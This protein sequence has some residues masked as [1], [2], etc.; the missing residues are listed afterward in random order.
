MSDRRY[1]SADVVVVGGGMSG[2]C[3]SIAAA[4]NGSS[5]VLIQDRPVLGGNAS[6]E[7]RMHIVG[8]DASGHRRGLDS[9][10]SG[11]IE[12]IRLEEAV[13]NP[14]RSASI[15]D[16]ILWEWVTREPNITLLLNTHC[17]GVEME[18]H[19]RI[20]KVLASR[21][22]TEDYFTISGKVF[23]DCSGDGRLGV[24]AG[25]DYRMGRE[26]RDEYGE[27]LAPPKA[28]SYVLGSTL[29]FITR[30][31]DH[32]VPFIAPDWI[33]RFP[34]CDDLPHRPH[35]DYE[36]G[37]WWVEWGGTRD[38]IKD[39]ELIRDELLKIAL[40]IWDHIKNQ[41]D[42]GAENWALDWVGFL[43]GKRESRRFLGD[44]VLTQSDLQNAV[45]FEDRVAYGGWPIDLHPPEGI[46]SSEPPC[47]QH[48]LEN[49]YSIPLRCL[50]SRNVENMFMAGRNI[51]ATHVAFASTRVMATCAVMGQAAGTAAALCARHG[52]TPRE[53]VRDGIA[54]LQQI[55]LKDDA[56][57]IDLANSDP[58]DLARGAKVKASSETECHEAVKVINGVSRSTKDDS[59]MWASDPKA[60]LPAWIELDLGAPRK[61]RE[62]H[63][64]FDTNLSQPLTLS[65]SD[66]F[67]ARMVRG[68]QPQTV[69]DYT[70][71][72]GSKEIV[73]ATGNYQR[74]AIH[75][76]DPIETQTIRLNVQA[77][78]G[79]P[80]ARVFEIR[81]Y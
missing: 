45:L 71:S 24:E 9:R 81:V 31:M 75:R 59:N 66:A 41:G 62:I 78:N 73:K 50:Y 4:R 7:V 12:E 51:S 14:Q 58:N 13:K 21:Y 64:T 23:M 29:L 79:A 34:S 60:G 46:Y 36:Y 22:S 63:L 16:L 32:P 67:T 74:K 10:E 39:N 28:D 3:A 56:Y 5:V 6:S 17:Y 18:S 49:L 69:R 55:L 53:L 15:F 80:S 38:T 47:A 52:I 20:A 42:H 61:V 43:P 65:H 25:A 2:V 44:H 37:Y 76:F 30:K 27:S 33:K 11:I 19:S 70:I 54:D 8:A 77:T 57:I 35:S 48:H 72:A 1:L 26:S 68:P 40:G